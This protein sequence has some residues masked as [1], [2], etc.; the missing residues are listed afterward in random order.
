MTPLLL[1]FSSCV[2]KDC[3]VC[4]Y[5][6]NSADCGVGWYVVLSPVFITECVITK[7][8]RMID[9]LKIK[10]G[11]PPQSYIKIARN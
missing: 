2:N 3:M 7:I 10:T 1:P 8:K 9:N 6:F 4:M 5:Y 11:R